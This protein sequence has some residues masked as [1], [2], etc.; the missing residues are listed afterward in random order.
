M[1]WQVFTLA[2]FVVWSFFVATFTM[3][4]VA[5][6]SSKMADRGQHFVKKLSSS[7]TGL[8]RSELLNEDCP[9]Y[10]SKQ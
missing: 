3:A 2:S 7:G 10:H 5:S 8:P 9:N 6:S 1:L 4:I